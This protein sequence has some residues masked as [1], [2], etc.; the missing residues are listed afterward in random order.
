MGLFDN[1]RRPLA[2]ANEGVTNL[3][4]VSPW[5]EGSLTQIMFSDLVGQDLADNLPLN[6]N[7]ALSVP[8]VAKARNLLCSQ[9]ARL[10]LKALDSN[11]VL[12]TQPSFLYRTNTPVSPYQRMA[13]TV[14]DL[15]FHGLSLWRLERGAHQPGSAYAPV[16]AAEWIPRQ[17]WE[18][19][20]SGEIWVTNEDQSRTHLADEDYVLFDVPGISGLLVH[21]ART[22]RGARDTERAWT[23]R[24]KNPVPT[25]EINVADDANLSEDEVAEVAATWNKARQ[26]PNG[27]VA[28]TPA[29]VTLKP[30]GGDSD[31]NLYLQNRNAI[32]SDVGA[33]V[34]VRAAML[35]STTG[36]SS[37]TYTTSQ[38]EQSAFFGLDLPLWT[39]AIEAALSQDKVVPSGQ[40]V[41]FDKSD[42]FNP[43]S[44]PTGNPGIED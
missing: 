3:A 24:I 25:L 7:E 23:S 20:T 38:G 37:L 39:D 35:D 43:N 19:D 32:R 26:S 36:Q 14:D 31:A 15:V 6:R 33:F 16:L 28:V 13:L 34:N 27:A 11:G 9:I 1:F 8:A 42:Q 2:I 21:A 4:M 10:P 22:I 29:G 44:T 18:I 5:Q 12:T 40:R 30:L 41:R 17:S